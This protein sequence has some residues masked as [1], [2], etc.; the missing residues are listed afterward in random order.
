[1][2]KCKSCGAE[3]VWVKTESGRTMPLDATPVDPVEVDRTCIIDNGVAKFG[4]IDCR[5]D[6]PHYVSHF[7][8]CPQA[9]QHRKEKA[10]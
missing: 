6:E 5:H 4:A 8:T 7:S 10:K 3:I 2:S 1:V 9:A